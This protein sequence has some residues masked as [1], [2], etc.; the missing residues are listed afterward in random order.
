M[1][2]ND[3]SAKRDCGSDLRFVRL[4]KKA[5]PD[6]GVSQAFDEGWS[7]VQSKC[8]RR[9]QA[10]L[11][12]CLFFAPFWNDTTGVGPMAKRDLEHIGVGR[13]FEI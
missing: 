7:E 5:D 13:H 12:I 8:G 11:R 6:S 4:D 1:K 3:W 2:F 9:I 10:A